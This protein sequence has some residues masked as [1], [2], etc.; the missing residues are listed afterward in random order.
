MKTLFRVYLHDAF[1]G[2]SIIMNCV[3]QKLVCC[4]VT[5][6]YAKKMVCKCYTAH[7]HEHSGKQRSHGKRVN[8]VFLATRC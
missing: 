6:R 5:I 4:F 8:I 3:D 7:K 1:E 2:T